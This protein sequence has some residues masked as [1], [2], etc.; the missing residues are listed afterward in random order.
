LHE[1]AP[2][3]RDPLDQVQRLV[4]QSLGIL[5]AAA[6]RVRTELPA[7]A[8]RTKEAD[9]VY[10]L[11][12]CLAE[13]RK[14]LRYITRLYP[15]GDLQVWVPARSEVESTVWVAIKNYTAQHALSE[16]DVPSNQKGFQYDAKTSASWWKALVMF[17]AS[18][19]K[20][21]EGPDCDLKHSLY[22]QLLSII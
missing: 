10:F 17:L 8:A 3:G 12:S 14:R 9:C 20:S 6:L 13:L 1:D 11:G 4:L 18:L 2:A 5:R 16:F 15:F 21:L 19:H 7:D 22:F